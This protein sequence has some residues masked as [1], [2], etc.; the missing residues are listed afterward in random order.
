[1]SG[2]RETTLGNVV[3]LR[4][5]HDL[6]EGE[7]RPGN[8]PVIGSAGQ[9]GWHDTAK[10][11]G[12]GVTVGRSG[13]SAGVVTYVDSDYWPHNTS[14]YVTNF[15]G[16]EPRFLAYY[17]STLRLAELNSGS[18]QPSLNRNFLYT[19]P[20]LLPSPNEQRRIASILS[21]YD[22]LIEVNRRRVAVP[23]CATS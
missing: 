5:G 3:R 22:N 21:T 18:A 4:R 15:C 13:A 14:L 10:A 17:F 12:P 11:S 6:T 19:V 23:P 8:V 16:N 9:N 20:V 7:R 2:W 1:M